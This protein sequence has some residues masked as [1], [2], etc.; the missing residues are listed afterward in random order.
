MAFVEQLLDTARPRGDHPAI[1]DG[2]RT[3]TYAELPAEIEAWSGRRRGAGI[4]PG[5]L[6]AVAM[7]DS[8]EHLLLLAALGNI[9]ATIQSLAPDLARRDMEQALG[10]RP[11]RALIADPETVLVEGPMRLTPKK[12]RRASPGAGSA[13]TVAPDDPFLLIQSS[14]T[15]G[16]PKTHLRSHAQFARWVRRYARAQGWVPSTRC[17]CMTPM[18]FNVGR[19]ISL[20]MLLTGATVVVHRPEPLDQT[21]ETVRRA[22]IT[23]LKVTPSH[24]RAF[25]GLDRADFPLFPTVLAMV[26]G[27]AP[28]LRAERDEARRRL[29]PNV[30]EQF[31]TNEGGLMA[32]AA[33]RDL[34]THPD[35]V[36]RVVEGI[37]AQ[38]VD[39]DGR[40]LPPGEVG[41]IRFRGDGIASAYLDDDDASARTFRDGWFYPGDLASLDRD[42][43]LF[44]KGR[45]DDVINNEGA[46]FYPVE[47]EAVLREHPAVAEAA[48]VGLAHPLH[49]EVAAAVLVVREAVTS[50]DLQAF[51]RRRLAP[52]KH[53]QVIAF[54]EA[55]PR[56]AMGKVDKGQIRDDVAG[57]YA[58][59]T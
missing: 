39:A 43:F 49:G 5:D 30:C 37:E 13:V 50:E 46:K 52:H 1:E 33:P 21:V 14:G 4:G 23:Y 26:C 32:F 22:G 18:S 58:A 15:T 6:V 16:Q 35:A 34:T 9:G 31:G 25:L 53:P 55:L 10:A 51:Y 2:A 36:G 41:E 59:R 17:F 20:G 40:C 3:V 7:A 19:S 27:S 24:L 38:V 54:V 29:T 11:V 42:G 12:L 47:V 44:H 28:L 8:A 57:A 48:V 45:V 56:N